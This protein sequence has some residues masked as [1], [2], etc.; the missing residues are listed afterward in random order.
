MTAAPRL[1]QRFLESTLIRDPG[2]PTLRAIFDPGTITSQLRQALP[3]VY[4]T[5]QNL[6][7]QVLKHHPGRRCTLEMAMETANGWSFAI[8]KVYATD[9]PHVFR[10]MQEIERAGFERENEFSIP[11]PLAYVPSLRLLLQEKVQGPRAKHVF[12]VGN[13][14]E[15]TRASL[16]CARWLAKFHA[17]GPRSGEILDAKAQEQEIARW[18]RRVAKVSEPLAEMATRLSR[19]LQEKAPEAGPSEWCAGHGSYNCNQIIVAEK[20]TTVFDWDSA[21]VADPCRDVARFV[22]ALQRL[23]FK[24][25][26]SIRA[27]DGIAEIFLKTYQTLSPFDVRA[28]L[29]W[30]RALTCLRLSKYEA[31][32]PVCTFRD[33]IQA[34]LSEGLR[35]L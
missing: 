30:Y 34:L 28:N 14:S 1:G 29:P 4:A 8:G 16:N 35:V 31:N 15:R 26:G 19:R 9:R 32:R 11:K 13:E 7:F 20:R 23:A 22:V 17:A 25:M 3:G 24:Y 33:G 5:V 12:L 21:D 18:P 27:L 2:I 10:A 6:R